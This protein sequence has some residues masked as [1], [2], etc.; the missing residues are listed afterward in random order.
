M[1]GGGVRPAQPYA[2][3]DGARRAGADRFQAAPPHD[4]LHGL[5]RT[6][7][8]SQHRAT[9]FRDQRRARPAWDRDD[10]DDSRGD[11]PAQ[12]RCSRRERAP[13]RGPLRRP[14]GRLSA[15]AP[16]QFDLL[17]SGNVADAAGWFHGQAYLPLRIRTFSESNSSSESTP[18]SWSAARRSSS[19]TCPEAGP[20]GRSTAAVE[21]VVAAITGRRRADAQALKRSIVSPSRACGNSR[22]AWRRS[23]STPSTSRAAKRTTPSG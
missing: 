2:N 4:H 21:P 19:P 3:S 18:V 9:L 20:T 22:A 16:L 5:V 14:A 8:D 13:P 15:S 6:S 12:H 1:G 23:S 11:G 10:R 7:W 17:L